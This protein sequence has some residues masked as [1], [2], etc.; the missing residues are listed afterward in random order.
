M[1]L[2]NLR[3]THLGR[4]MDHLSR[5]DGARLAEILGELRQEVARAPANLIACAALGEALALAG[6]ADEARGLALRTYE[7]MQRLPAVGVELLINV[8]AAL[9]EAGRFV[10]AKRCLE[11]ALVREPQDVLIINVITLA[12]RFGELAWLERLLPDNPVSRFLQQRD[13]DRDW[14]RQQTAVEA[15]LGR[16]VSTFSAH[17]EDFRD[18]SVRLVLDYF[19]DT[20]DPRRI[21]ELDDSVWSAVEEVYQTHPAGPGALLGAVVLNVHGIQCPL[22]EAP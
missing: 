5:D 22:P 11:Q 18:G 3:A 10:E 9:G 19:L 14:P 15:I 16:H 13:L 12:I 17:L 2:L 21:A 20:V 7:Q 4:E 1:A 6:R 8:G